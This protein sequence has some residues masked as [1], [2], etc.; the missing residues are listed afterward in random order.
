MCNQSALDTGNPTAATTVSIQLT[1]ESQLSILERIATGGMSSVHRA[2]VK[3]TGEEVALKI[4]HSDTQGSFMRE[5]QILTAI[6]NHPNVVKLQDS[7]VLEETPMCHALA[8]EFVPGRQLRRVV[9]FSGPLVE[10]VAVDIAIQLLNAVSH[11][12]HLHIMHRDIKS[13]NV[14][15]D[16]QLGKLTVI[17][18]GLACFDYDAVELKRRCGT[19]GYAAPELLFRKP[20]GLKVDSFASGCL[21]YAVFCGRPIFRGS[22][23]NELLQ[24]NAAAKIPE[25]SAWKNLREPSKDLLT[26]LLAKAVEDRLLPAEARELPIFNQV[27]IQTVQ[28]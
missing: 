25:G 23:K 13:E 22:T 3:A 1:A 12:H 5:L 11:L 15:Y 16:A 19:P 18:L 26:S 2:K 7:Y 9:D 10:S 4:V 20:Y 14:M 28:N 24:K 8:L 27:S 21:L 17:D 6:G